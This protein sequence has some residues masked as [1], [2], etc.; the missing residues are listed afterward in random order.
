LVTKDF[1]IKIADFGLA[2]IFEPEEAMH[3]ICGTLVTM[4]PEIMKK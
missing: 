1:N 2:K 3:S 4:A